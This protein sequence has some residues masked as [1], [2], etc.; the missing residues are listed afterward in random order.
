MLIT[1]LLQYQQAIPSEILK[2]ALIL[3]GLRTI[4]EANKQTF[5]F[6]D[7]TFN[8][9][10][11]PTNHLQS[12]ILHYNTSTARSTIRSSPQRTYPPVSTSS[13]RPYQQT[14]H[15]LTTPHLHTRKHSTKVGT[16]TF[17]IT[18]LQNKQ[19]EN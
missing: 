4:I 2:E 11:A 17:Y 12:R 1:F 15:P 3:N 9:N 8:P 19:T 18:N 10:K 13:C 6:L 5:S 14:K 16:I 7:V